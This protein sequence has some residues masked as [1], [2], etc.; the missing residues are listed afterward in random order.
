MHGK[1]DQRRR[2][3]TKLCHEKACFQGQSSSLSI[4]TGRH[5][6]KR[7]TEVQLRDEGFAVATGKDLDTIA[8]LS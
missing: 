5:W 1:V 2:K 6:Y 3:K 8:F 4:R 7:R